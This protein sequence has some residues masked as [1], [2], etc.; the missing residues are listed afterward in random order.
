MDDLPI[1]PQGEQVSLDEI[2]DPL[3]PKPERK[4]LLTHALVHHKNNN[5]QWKEAPDIHKIFLAG[6]YFIH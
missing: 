4:A 1:V 6:S 2:Q 5:I 3:D